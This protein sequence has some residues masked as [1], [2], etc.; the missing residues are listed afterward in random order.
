MERQSSQEHCAEAAPAKAAE[1]RS[2]VM[3]KIVNKTPNLFLNT[4]KHLL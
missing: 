1:P 2:A 4:D 3:V